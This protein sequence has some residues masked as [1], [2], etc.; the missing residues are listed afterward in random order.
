MFKSEPLPDSA[1]ASIVSNMIISTPTQS[2]GL[3][4]P[5]TNPSPRPS[6][7]NPSPNTPPS[8]DTGGPVEHNEDTSWGES[9]MHAILGVSCVHHVV[10]CERTWKSSADCIQPLSA[11]P[12]SPSATFPLP[13]L[14]RRIERRNM[15]ITTRKN[16]DWMSR[17]HHVTRPPLHRW[18]NA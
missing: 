5:A 13:Q 14:P 2:P 17:Y 11:S 8:S 7:T 10:S 16:K 1:A 18:R 9:L 4:R 12:P 6:V 15:P 3:L